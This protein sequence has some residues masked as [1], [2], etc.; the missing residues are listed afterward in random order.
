[1]GPDGVSLVL[2]GLVKLSEGVE[3]GLFGGF[4]FMLEFSIFQE[5]WFFIFFPQAARFIALWIKFEFYIDLHNQLSYPYSHPIN[6]STLLLSFV[7]FY[8]RII[9]HTFIN[10]PEL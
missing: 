9:R 6:L 2:L 4:L 5:E 7:P 8:S 1:M 10:S 3:F